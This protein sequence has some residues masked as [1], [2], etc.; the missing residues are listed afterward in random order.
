MVLV[1]ATT[2]IEDERI[3]LGSDTR[4]QAA[5]AT[6]ADLSFSERTSQQRKLL[7][8]MMTREKM[9]QKIKKKDM[10]GVV[11]KN[12]QRKIRR[13][14]KEAR[15]IPSH[16]EIKRKEFTI[17]T[18]KIWICEG[19]E[20]DYVSHIYFCKWTLGPLY[21]YTPFFVCNFFSSSIFF[22]QT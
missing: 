21:Y 19:H 1:Y 7:L 13:G 3:S 14:K 16:T 17:S 10:C 6:D 9:K 5:S 12:R 11:P 22:F 2:A 20:C 15:Y 18:F 8:V 4:Q